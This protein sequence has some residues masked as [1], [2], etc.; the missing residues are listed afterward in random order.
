MSGTKKVKMRMAQSTELN[1]KCMKLAITS[2]EE[3]MNKIIKKANTAAPAAVRFG[4][5]L[6]RSNR[7][8]MALSPVNFRSRAGQAKAKLKMMPGRTTAGIV[9]SSGMVWPKLWK[10]HAGKI[11]SA[12]SK[13][14]MYQSG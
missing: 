4:R 9:T 3:A 8:W 13:N 14:P 5:K 2:V 10:L 7:W 6:G 12:P 1:D 11:R